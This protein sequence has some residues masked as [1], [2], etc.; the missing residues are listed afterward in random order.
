MR[1]DKTQLRRLILPVLIF[2]ACA[3]QICLLHRNRNRSR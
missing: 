3:A 2:A 1:L